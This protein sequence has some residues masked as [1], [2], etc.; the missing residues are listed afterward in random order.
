M[1]LCEDNVMVHADLTDLPFEAHSFD[2]VYCSHVLE[3]VPDDQQAMRELRRILLPGGWALFQVPI[4]RRTT[5]ED[6]TITSPE[7][8]RELFGQPD[9]VR[10][11]GRDFRQRLARAG[12]AVSVDRPQD[13]LNRED[14]EFCG[15]QA[16]EHIFLCRKK[17]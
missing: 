15:L 17:A 7:L 10:I 4:Q 12:F 14:L 5:F 6:P 9:H 11:Y 3:H 8:R 1:D 16:G 2:G 13:R